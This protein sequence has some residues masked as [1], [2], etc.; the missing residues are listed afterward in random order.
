[1]QNQFLRE[2]E[3][4]KR[5]K[6]DIRCG[7]KDNQGSGA[8]NTTAQPEQLAERL[9][10]CPAVADRGNWKLKTATRL[11]HRSYLKKRC[12][13]REHQFNR[14]NEKEGEMIDKDKAGGRRLLKTP[15][16]TKNCL[17]YPPGN[18][19]GRKPKRLAQVVYQRSR[20]VK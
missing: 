15:S 6:G 16:T 12:V 8:G 1:M 9:K 17:K 10:G 14:R 18:E 13:Q 3:G 7:N 20:F 5:C 11:S 2:G 4:A 19:S